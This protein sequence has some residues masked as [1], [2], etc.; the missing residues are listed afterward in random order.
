LY[1]VGTELLYVGSL[2]EI[3]QLSMFSSL[4][5]LIVSQWSFLVIL[6]TFSTLD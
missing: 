1:H 4:V 5:F 3:S 6:V 2:T